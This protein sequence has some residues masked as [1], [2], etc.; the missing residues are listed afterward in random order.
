[1]KWENTYALGITVLDAQHKQLFVL[2]NELD[3]GLSTGIRSEEL[4]G[5]LSRI[6]DYAIRHFTMEEKYM[7]ELEYP[8]L[9]Q[10]QKIHKAFAKQFEEMYTEF[11]ENGLKKEIIEKVRNELTDWVRSHVTGID[12]RFGEYCKNRK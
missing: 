3:A 5:M 8:G 6:G 7:A 12:Q 11:K 9:A 10:Q 4:D 1:M 2:S